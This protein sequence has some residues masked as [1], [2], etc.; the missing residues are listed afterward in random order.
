MSLPG[1]RPCVQRRGR[2]SVGPAGVPPVVCGTSGKAPH[3]QSAAAVRRH[4]QPAQQLGS[5]SG[6]AAGVPGGDGVSRLSGVPAAGRRARRV[7][8]VLAA[9]PAPGQGTGGRSDAAVTRPAAATLEA[10][11]GLAKS[12]P[13]GDDAPPP[14][15]STLLATPLQE[16][17]LLRRGTLP[18]GLRYCVLPNGVPSGRFEAHLEMHVGSVDEREDEQGLA[19]LVEHVTFLGSPKRDRLLGSFWL[20][21]VEAT[22]LGKC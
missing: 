19:H 1:T 8:Q 20:W 2:L 4:G 5:S 22:N 13:S 16:H 21:L 11:L 15:P 6:L 3:R 14:S 10:P 12:S 9:V 18:N 7:P 17:P